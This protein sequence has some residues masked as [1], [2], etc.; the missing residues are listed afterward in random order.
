MTIQKQ[1]SSRSTLACAGCLILFFLVHGFASGNLQQRDLTPLQ[2][3]IRTQLTRLSSPE[4]EERRDAVMRLGA[5]RHPEAS[6]AA[7]AGLRD[8]LPI[9]RAAATAAIL[10]LPAD[11]S[12]VALIPL[13]NDKDEFVR[14]E[15]AYALGKTKSR[16]AVAPLVERL[17]I[18]KKDGVR[19]AA[20]VALGQ[21]GDE[22]AVVSLA[23]ILNF[24]GALPGAKKATK[25]KKKENA[26]VM[27][28]AARS[29]G[30]IGSR[31]GVPALLTVVEDE[32]T[33]DDVRREAA[34]ALG[35][36]GDP[37]ALPALRKLQTAQDPALSLTAFEAVRKISR[38]IAPRS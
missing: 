36:I 4:V 33:E 21:I 27:R 11:E 24:H 19:G 15:A 1:L 3:E 37:T 17:S 28:A 2:L 9:V 12:A 31:A 6:R 16:S 18:D 38:R 13:L 8:A 10:W 23:Q 7:V 14:Q 30:Q 25:K 32:K 35:L 22:A 5:L 29:L 26:L 20:A 34:G